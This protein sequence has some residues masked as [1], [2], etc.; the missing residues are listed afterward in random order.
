MLASVTKVGSKRLGTF[1]S[2]ESEE[3]RAQKRFFHA[4]FLS[5]PLLMVYRRWLPCSIAVSNDCLWM[6][7]LGAWEPPDS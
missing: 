5:P 3:N 1:E 2:L 7:L 6:E 4:P